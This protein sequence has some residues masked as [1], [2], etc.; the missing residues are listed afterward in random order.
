MDSVRG[1]RS[2]AK[3][4]HFREIHRITKTID[5]ARLAG[6][7]PLRQLFHCV[8]NF[9]RL[10]EKLHSKPNCATQALSNNG[11]NKIIDVYRH[12]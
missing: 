10:G 7:E 11:F 2:R 5:L 9:A 12:V 4:E 1:Y 8:N 6:R 3:A